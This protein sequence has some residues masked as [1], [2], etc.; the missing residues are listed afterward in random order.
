MMEDMLVV[1]N[2]TKKYKGKTVLDDISFS[3]K[4]GEVVGLVGPNGA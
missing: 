4:K 1:K 3:M 2:L